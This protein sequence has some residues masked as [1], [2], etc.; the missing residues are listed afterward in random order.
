MWV[1][2]MRGNDPESEHY[3][4]AP[5]LDVMNVLVNA[6]GRVMVIGSWVAAPARGD[7]ALPRTAP[8]TLRRRP[9]TALTLYGCSP[10]ARSLR[11]RSICR[12]R[13]CARRLRA[14]RATLG[15]CSRTAWARRRHA[16]L[17]HHPCHSTPG[18]SL[19]LL[20]LRARASFHRE[21]VRQLAVA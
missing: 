11:P 13:A 16:C 1:V 4:H 14:A 6:V 2:K 7:L 12:R 21:G 18:R 15:P 10:K 5:S 8:R 9:G 20:A 17:L 19:P 3:W